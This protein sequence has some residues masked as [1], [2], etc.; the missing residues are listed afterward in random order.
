MQRKNREL[1][2]KKQILPTRKPGIINAKH[3]RSKATEEGKDNLQV[4]FIALSSTFNKSRLNTQKTV[5]TKNGMISNVN[6]TMVIYG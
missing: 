1:T 6:L 5:L 4:A 3:I 2:L